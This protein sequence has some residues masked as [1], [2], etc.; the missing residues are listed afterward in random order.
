MF[1]SRSRSQRR[2]TGRVGGDVS[3][4][5]GGAGSGA[6]KGAEPVFSAVGGENLGVCLKEIVG[7]EDKSDRLLL[8]LGA[9][10]ERLKKCP[11]FPNSVHRFR[12]TW[13]PPSTR[14]MY[15]ENSF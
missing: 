4:L 6:G 3:R 11:S 14:S 8:L 12:E 13:Q 7:V 9:E 15:R 5:D 2:S 10:L 1:I